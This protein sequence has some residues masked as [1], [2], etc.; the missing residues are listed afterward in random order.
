MIKKIIA[1]I[2]GLVLLY[3]LWFL[4]LR[5]AIAG[6]NYNFLSYP[7]NSATPSASINPCFP[8]E[9]WSLWE[10]KSSPT[11]CP[12]LTPSPSATASAIP[13][14]IPSNNNSIPDTGCAVTDCNTHKN[15]TPMVINQSGVPLYPP[16]NAPK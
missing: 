5:P 15:D 3:G 4:L 14:S 9:G 2:L 7:G 6:N 16:S 12:S 11:P 10:R 8:K 1:I 13:S